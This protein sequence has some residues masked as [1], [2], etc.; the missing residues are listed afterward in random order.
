LLVASAA[1][2]ALAGA[3]LLAINAL[4]S[5]A[6]TAAPPAVQQSVPAIVYARYV[7]SFSNDDAK[8]ALVRGA[9]GGQSIV[10]G[11]KTWWLFGDTLFLAE[12][13]KPIEQNSIAWSDSTGAD[14]CPK[15]HYYARNGVALPFLAKDGSLTAWPAGAWASSD[16]TIDFYTAYVYGSGPYA[17]WIGEVGLARLDTDSMQVDVLSR[18]LWDASS[19]LVDQVVG[20]QPVETDADGKLRLVLQTKLSTKLLARVAPDHAADITAYEYWD[21]SGW[22]AAAAAAVPLWQQPTGQDDVHQLASFENGASIAWND[23]LH[24]YLAIVNTSFS[25]IGV[26]TADRLEGPWSEPRPWLDCLEFTQPAVPACYSPLQHPQLG[27]DGGRRIFT[28]LTRMSTYDVVAF[29]LTLGTAIHEYRRNGDVAYGTSPPD[30]GG[31]VDEGAALSASATQLPGLVPVFRWTRGDESRY[32]TATSPGQSYVRGDPAF[33]AAPGS[34]V[35]GSSLTYQ[36][37][38]DWHSGTKHVL[39]LPDADLT[40]YGYQRGDIMFYAP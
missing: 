26:R 14:G 1:A 23:A 18:K 22:S 13:G 15:L 25:A 5:S 4:R 36:P 35:T 9:D 30:G 6:S 16:H 28:T 20:T 3:V 17:Y 39:A 38:Y 33:Y 29:E 34:N 24:T 10:V 31:W 32:A 11:N 27:G 2:A 7:C 8:A 21:G 40:Q 37:V 12:A 19:G